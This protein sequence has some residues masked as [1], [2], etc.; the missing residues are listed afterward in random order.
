MMIFDV[1]VRG[2]VPV[3]G[4]MLSDEAVAHE[5]IKAG[6][7]ELQGAFYIKQARCRGPICRDVIG[8]WW[9]GSRGT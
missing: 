7:K 9:M 2:I 4:M 8:Q 1:D 3:Y 6:R 5:R